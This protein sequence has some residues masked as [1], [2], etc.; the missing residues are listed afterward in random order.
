[1]IGNLTEK[2]L[3]EKTSQEITSILY[4]ACIE[5]LQNAIIAIN[6]ND[7]ENAN[8]LLQR[9]NDIIY[10]LGAGIKYEA[11]IIADQLDSLYNY[12]A[13]L[14]IEANLKKDVRPIKV[15]LKIINEIS[16]AWDIAM[17]KGVDRGKPNRKV[18]KYEETNVTGEKSHTYYK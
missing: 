10:R 7:Y 4:K 8:Y 16:E 18:L 12:A 17:T 13:E 6:N 1:M 2:I 9:C 3:L 14:L 5:K 11:G 15:V